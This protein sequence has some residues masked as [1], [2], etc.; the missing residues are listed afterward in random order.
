MI[1]LKKKIPYLESNKGKIP[2]E[3]DSTGEITF[4]LR[5]F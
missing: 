2:F 1:F 3:F 5:L 4:P